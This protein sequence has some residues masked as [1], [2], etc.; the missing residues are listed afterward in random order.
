MDAPARALEAKYSEITEMD[1]GVKPLVSEAMLRMTNRNVEQARALEFV[2][3][4][5]FQINKQG[6]RKTLTNIR[7]SELQPIGRLMNF[8]CNYFTDHAFRY[9]IV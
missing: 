5:F 3:S 4:P 2:P 8:N 6:Y 1:D 9:H 7:I